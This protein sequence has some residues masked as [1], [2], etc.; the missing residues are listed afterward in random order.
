MGEVSIINKTDRYKLKQ[1]RH[2]SNA[3]IVAWHDSQINVVYCMV[4]DQKYGSDHNGN[5]AYKT[6]VIEKGAAHHDPTVKMCRLEI[7]YVEEVAAESEVPE[8]GKHTNPSDKTQESPLDLYFA[9]A[10]SRLDF[11][12]QLESLLCLTGRRRLFSRRRCDSPVLIR[13]LKEIYRANDI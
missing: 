8:L 10:N 3:V 2:G 6:F 5:P 11:Q 13:L 12:S 9:G 4:S 1:T 7:A